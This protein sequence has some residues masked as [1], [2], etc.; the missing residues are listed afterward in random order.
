MQPVAGVRSDQLSAGRFL[1][2]I[3]LMIPP[4]S[5]RQGGHWFAIMASEEIHH[6]YLA[7]ISM[8]KFFTPSRCRASWIFPDG[9]PVVSADTRVVAHTPRKLTRTKEEP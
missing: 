7:D 8:L 5:I 9:R 6:G 3:L 4:V 1:A 2:D